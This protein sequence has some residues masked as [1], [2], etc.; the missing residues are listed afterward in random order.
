MTIPNCSTQPSQPSNHYLDL[1]QHAELGPLC[2]ELP[3]APNHAAAIVVESTCTQARED[4]KLEQARLFAFTGY[5]GRSSV[6]CEVAHL[7]RHP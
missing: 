7:H 2:Q 6:P 5:A 1:I 4:A 3:I